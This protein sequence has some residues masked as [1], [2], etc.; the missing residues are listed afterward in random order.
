MSIVDAEGNITSNKVK[1]G[2]YFKW[3]VVSGFLLIFIGVVLIVGVFGKLTI[4][5][6]LVTS[7]LG[8]I[9]YA[10]GTEAK[11]M[12]NNFNF[13]LVGSGA[14]AV[15][16][17]LLANKYIAE[18]YLHIH[19]KPDRKIGNVYH[20]DLV[21][22]SS[23][24]GK[25]N[26]ETESYEFVV[27][28]PEIKN[29]MRI[30]AVINEN[31]EDYESGC[32]ATSHVEGYLSSGGTLLWDL[33]E[34]SEVFVSNTDKKIASTT[35]CTIA[36][37]S[38]PSANFNIIS[39]AYAED[40][41]D[42]TPQEPIAINQLLESLDSDSTFKRRVA[43]EQLADAGVA[44][45]EPVV[46]LISSE[47]A[48]YREKLGGYVALSN[49]VDSKDVDK[50][51]IALKIEDA[52]LENIYSSINLQE[53]TMKIYSTNFLHNLQDARLLSYSLESLKEVD[54][55]GVSREQIN[56]IKST[57]KALEQKDKD[58][59][60]S[61]LAEINSPQSAKVMEEITKD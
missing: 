20:M 30:K 11:I 51:E 57:F 33:R 3:T 48:S 42:E 7:G 17:F 49:L 47:S 39:L 10:F 59:Y 23:Y 14:V 37:K 40:R 6:M 4:N 53:S 5:L 45:V 55:D 28:G 32:I 21:G 38:P 1:F 8:I 19:I 27:F 54:L 24:K 44:I 26:K 36:K 18:G 15:I 60:L 12:D 31:E 16:L 2:P 35:S 43:R 25:Y 29:S 34:G 52:Q 56:V 50:T 41:Q 46:D 58:E 22:D 13:V 61:K 9:F